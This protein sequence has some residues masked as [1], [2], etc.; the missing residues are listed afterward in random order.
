MRF[1]EEFENKTFSPDCLNSSMDVDTTHTE[2]A[3]MS[4]LLIDTVSN[5]CSPMMK[6]S[7]TVSNWCVHQD[8]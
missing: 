2:K 4:S 5:H 8:G 7:K 6:E 1:V 3:N